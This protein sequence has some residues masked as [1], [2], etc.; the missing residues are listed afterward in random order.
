VSKANERV[1]K[2]HELVPKALERCHRDPD[3]DAR[4]R[5]RGIL[6]PFRLLR[7]LDLAWHRGGQRQPPL[8]LFALPPPQM[9][10]AERDARATCFESELECGVFAVALDQE[11]APAHPARGGIRPGGHETVVD[12]ASDPMSLAAHS[13]DPRRARPT[14][15]DAA[16]RSNVPSDPFHEPVPEVLRGE[17]RRPSSSPDRLAE[18]V[19]EA[20]PAPHHDHRP[21]LRL[22]VDVRPWPDPHRASF[23]LRHQRPRVCRSPFIVRGTFTTGARRLEDR[24]RQTEVVFVVEEAPEGGYT[25]RALGA[26][27][28]AEADSPDELQGRVRDAVHCHFEE[29]DRPT[30]IRLHYIRE[31]LIAV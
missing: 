10:E 24:L 1:P 29:A 13:H 8:G 28:F 22:P 3:R 2:A 21:A 4:R 15:R 11:S 14:R 26:S 9:L 7:I 23:S 31:Q 19:G 30:V 18:V 20:D 16:P 27:I 12:A 17:E 6:M 25:A 5:R